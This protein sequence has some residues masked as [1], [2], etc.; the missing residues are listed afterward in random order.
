MTLNS[1][2]HH[3]AITRVAARKVADACDACMVVT[4]IWRMASDVVSRLRKSGPGGCCHACEYETALMLHLQKR[5]NMRLAVDEPVKSHS[6]F[7]AGDM[8][9]PGSKIFWSTWRYQKSR[10]GTYGA[11]TL[12]TAEQGR[13][14]FDGTIEAYLRLLR[15]VRRAPAVVAG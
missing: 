1:H 10:T 7:V 15:E 2:G 11:P 4:D 14:M 6:A 13:R 3:D 5:V 8:I 12:A 9:G